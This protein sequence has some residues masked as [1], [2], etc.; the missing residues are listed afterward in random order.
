MTRESDSTDKAMIRPDS[1]SP[2]FSVIVVN[3]NGGTYLQAAVDSLKEQTFQNFELIVIDN[4]S[5]D[6]SANELDLSGLIDAQL[7]KNID[8]TGFAAANNQ[9]AKLARGRWL[10]LLNPD[11][12]AAPDWLEQFQLAAQRFPDCKVFACTQYSLDNEGI[13]DGAGDAYLV[14]GVPWRGGFG[15]SVSKLPDTGLCFSPCGAGALYDRKLFLSIDGFDERYFCYCEDVDIG[16]RLQLL[17]EPCVFV[18]EATIHHAG[19]AISGR[20]SEFSSYHGTRNRIWTYFKNMPLALLL[21]T[22]PAHLLIS[23][24]L[25]LRSALIGCFKPTLRATWHGFR[26]ALNLRASNQWKVRKRKVS[27]WALSRTMAW[28]PFTMNRR[29]PHVRPQSKRAVGM[30]TKSGAPIASIQVPAAR[31]M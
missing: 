13:L 23:V 30:E 20:R 2:V 17:G 14:L 7:V 15:H 31:D 26:D 5:E 27:V 29:L 19:S 12:T 8:N 10:A 6:G 4:A 11:A 18:R 9:A 1:D 28:N 25:I 3:Y 24:Y 21:I 16:F 22:L